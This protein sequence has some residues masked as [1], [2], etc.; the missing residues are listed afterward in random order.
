MLSIKTLDNYGNGKDKSL[1]SQILD[2]LRS[3]RKI[4]IQYVDQAGPNIINFETSSQDSLQSIG[5]LSSALAANGNVAESDALE[6]AIAKCLERREFGGLGLSQSGD[7]PKGCLEEVLFLVDA[8]LEAI[9]SQERARKTLLPVAVKS[10]ETKPM[11]LAEK[12]FAHH[13]IGGCPAEGLK[14][15]DMVRVS[16]DWVISSELSWKVSTL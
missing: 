8:W 10:Q 12:I 13:T 2:L 15:G 11:T 16:V 1:I 7:I 4:N 6:N 3:I 14:V 5:Q 9:N